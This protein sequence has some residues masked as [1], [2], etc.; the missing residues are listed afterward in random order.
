MASRF[1][2]KW[3]IIFESNVDLY[4]S[5][6]EVYCVEGESDNLQDIIF[7]LNHNNSS[8]YLKIDI[9]PSLNGTFKFLI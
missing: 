5:A 3:D 4:L 1:G 8:G 9:C 2:N 7:R 6:G